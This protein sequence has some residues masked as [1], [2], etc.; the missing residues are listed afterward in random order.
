MDE[1]NLITHLVQGLP[2]C[3][4]QRNRLFEC[5][6]EIVPCGDRLLAA[7]IDEYTD[8]EDFFHAF[9]PELLG[10]NLATATISDLLAA[11]AVPAWYLHVVGLPPDREGRFSQGLMKGIG[12]ALAHN[13]AWLLGGDVSNAPRWRYVGNAL[14]FVDRH[15][16]L[17]TTD[18]PHLL[19]YATGRFGAGNLAA[20]D[21]AYQPR[22]ESRAALMGR[23]R[24][25]VRLGMDTSDGLRSTLVTL[26]RLNPRHRF[27]V[28]VDTVPIHSHL[29]V[30]CA[31]TGIPSEG[32]LFGS[33]GEYELV[34]GIDPADRDRAEDLFQGEAACIGAM[35]AT[36]AAPTGLHWN[37]QGLSEPR[38]DIPL[39]IDPRDNPDREAYVHEILSA[40]GRLFYS[41]GARGE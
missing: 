25:L 16:V 5:D 35:S 15:P 31:K 8:E 40:I 6:A 18:R 23:L 27:V 32:F 29:Q 33:A 10:W 17:R 14:G 37:K 38:A 22:F 36:S 19:L 12:E 1:F 41:P 39:T 9:D 13:H 7:T 2:R 11:G 30:F 3:P 24:P 21:H 26:A 28:D 34:L 20:M 4:D